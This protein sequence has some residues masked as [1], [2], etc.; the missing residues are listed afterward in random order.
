MQARGWTGHKSPLSMTP[1][2]ITV[3]PDPIEPV[4][5]MRAKLAA[6]LHD[7]LS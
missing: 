7:A 3:W 1:S 4:E 6:K 5:D 2:Q